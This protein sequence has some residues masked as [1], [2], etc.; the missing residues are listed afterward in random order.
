MLYFEIKRTSE[1]IK[2]LNDNRIKL[3]NKKILDVGCHHGWYSNL[4]AY[5]TNSADGVYGIDFI[6]EFIKI[7]KNINSSINYIGGDIY[8]LNLNKEYFDFIL[9]NY[10]FNAFPHEDIEKIAH[11][12]SSKVK[13]NGYILYFDFYRSTV[14]TFIR[15]IRK[16]AHKGEPRLNIR[17]I[18]K[19]FPDFRI[20]KSKRMINI[21]IL[22][23]LLRI[24]CYPPHW[25]VDIVTLFL[26]K[27]YFV[28]LLQK[29]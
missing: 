23:Y 15:K 8:D 6:P 7:A 16:L 22:K 13:S 12:I 5:L 19:I 11:I 2:I 17:I 14:L 24:R 20:V 29:E 28:V 21:R 25:L 18:K 27:N 26:R 1:F 3:K 4:F 10:V 9:C